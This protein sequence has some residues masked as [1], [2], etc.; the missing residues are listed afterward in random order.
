M[1]HLPLPP[2]EAAETLLVFIGPSV[3]KAKL[4]RKYLEVRREH[5]RSAL[6]WLRKHNIL[7]KDVQI[8]EEQINEYPTDLS[9][10][11]HVVEDENAGNIH[12]GYFERHGPTPLHLQEHVQNDPRLLAVGYNGAATLDRDAS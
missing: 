9:D 12:Q 8:D 2:N 11:V 3:D 5:L 4:I 6:V 1:T 7:Y 10:N